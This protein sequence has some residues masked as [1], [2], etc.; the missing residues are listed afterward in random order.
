MHEDLQVK[1]GDFGLATVKS[2]FSHIPPPASSAAAFIHSVSGS[3]SGDSTGGS[4]IV[5]SHSTTGAATVSS[6]GGCQPTGSILWMAP[7]VIRMQPPSPYSFQSDVYSFG[8]VV[9]ELA[10]GRLPYECKAKDAILFMVGSGR[11]CPD[12]ALVSPQ[13]PKP[14]IR[15]LRECTQFEAPK[16]PLFRQIL[17]SLEAL[18]QSQ[19]NIQRSVSEPVSLNRFTSYKSSFPLLHAAASSS[20]SVSDES[21]SNSF[22]G[23]QESLPAS[24]GHRPRATDLSFVPGQ[25]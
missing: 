14:L 24:A 12:P 8:V 3:S 13:T 4:S 15:L 19:P 5:G 20:E 21:E 25:V 22:D 17:A 9:F 10:S 16:R 23:S 6:A 1:I 2:R 7:E 11:W 18:L